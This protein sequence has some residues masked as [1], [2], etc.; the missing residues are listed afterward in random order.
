MEK[1]TIVFESG[2]Y[3]EEV[4]WTEPK[5]RVISCMDAGKDVG[6]RIECGDQSRYAKCMFQVLEYCYYFRIS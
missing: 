3:K 4:I 5:I 1:G 2:T 6:Y